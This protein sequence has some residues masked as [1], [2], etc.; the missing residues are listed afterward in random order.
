MTGTRVAL[1]F[2]RI[3]EGGTIRTTPTQ[4]PRTSRSLGSRYPDEARRNT[5]FQAT[6]PSPQPQEDPTI[7]RRDFAR[8]PPI[9]KK[10]SS[11]SSGQPPKTARI[12][13]PSR[14][15]IE[16]GSAIA[17][18]DD[19]QQ[20]IE[21]QDDPTS[22]TKQKARSPSDTAAKSAKRKTAFYVGGNGTTRKRP[23]TMRK[24]SS[25]S[26]SSTSS[27]KTSPPS[28]N[29]RE[30]T[31]TQGDEA[32]ESPMTSST[33]SEESSSNPSESEDS[34]DIRRSEE[35]SPEEQG[36]ST[37]R[38]L[39][40]AAVP[41]IDLVQ[42]DFR[43]KF[44]EQKQSEQR[45]FTALPLLSRKSSASVA[46]SASAHA[47]GTIGPSLQT[48]PPGTLAT[49]SAGGQAP[50]PGLQMS[51]SQLTLLLEKGRRRSDEESR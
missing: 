26:S 42:R 38:P 24:R 39:P 6:I 32:N 8:P 30:T 43:T 22:S 46:T 41:S 18:D 29:T 3:N 45:Q 11:E 16:Y 44:A 21:E 2:S 19:E 17:D 36:A 23:V 34:Q 27:S 10:S 33:L 4:S 25:Q 50:S 28:L 37:P 1:Q 13:S 35:G 15:D 9:L 20:D 5:T 47:A 31:T 14:R 51:K 49:T 7:L 12:V 48:L 40:G